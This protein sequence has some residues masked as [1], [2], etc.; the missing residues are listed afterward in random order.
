MSLSAE[1][2]RR[3]TALA[4]SSTEMSLLSTIPSGLPVQEAPLERAS[5]TESWKAR[6][7]RLKTEHEA[8]EKVRKHV[9]E[10]SQQLQGERNLR[11]K[12]EAQLGALEYAAEQQALE[13]EAARQHRQSANEV[14]KSAN[15]APPVPRGLASIANGCTETVWCRRLRQER[16][17]EHRQFAKQLAAER[18]QTE[19]LRQEASEARQ[20][21]ARFQLKNER[22]IS[23]ET[24]ERRNQSMATLIR[25]NKEQL[26]HYEQMHHSLRQRLAALTAELNELRIRADHEPERLRRLLEEKN[27]E[28]EEYRASLERATED[29]QAA[30]RE[31]KEEQQEAVGDSAVSY[32]ILLVCRL[33]IAVRTPN[34]YIKLKCCFD[35][36]VQDIPVWFWQ[37]SQGRA[38]TAR[39]LAGNIYKEWLQVRSQRRSRLRE[40]LRLYKHLLRSLRL[41]AVQLQHEREALVLHL[42]TLRKDGAKAICELLSTPPPPRPLFNRVPH[43]RTNDSESP[44]KSELIRNS[45]VQTNAVFAWQKRRKFWPP[46]SHQLPPLP[47]S[48]P[49]F[50]AK[51]DAEGWSSHRVQGF[52]QEESVN[53]HTLQQSQHSLWLGN[54]RKPSI[55][56]HAASSP[57]ERSRIASFQN[58]ETQRDVSS[59]D[60]RLCHREASPTAV[61]SWDFVRF[62]TIGDEYLKSAVPAGLSA[63]SHGKP[64]K[65]CPLHGQL[66]VPLAP[67][68]TPKGML[69]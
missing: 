57:S 64:A 6:L 56:G 41:K 50:A 62:A 16:L 67:S 47:V 17:R 27:Q 33:Q 12:L 55:V 15:C 32:L 24:E 59:L 51:A 14:L 25:E 65:R 3:L 5:E 20:E 40:K 53:G 39:G 66:N 63:Q 61:N 10:L 54:V 38:R 11:A 7:G 21:A 1:C 8:N 68:Q 28:T 45:T 26:E 30:A 4:S 23:V 58:T 9:A 34:P 36:D 37:D 52:A 49:N 18:Q 44:A 48:A 42:K 35:A 29:I 46:T 19:A 69:V 13:M 2:V 60:L 43:Q 22:Q 31:M